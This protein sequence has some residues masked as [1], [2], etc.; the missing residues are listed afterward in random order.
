M[1][2]IIASLFTLFTITA[3]FAQGDFRFAV[4]PDRTGGHRPGIY[5]DAIRKLNLMQPEF[6]MSVGDLIEGYTEDSAEVIRQWEEYDSLIAPLNMPFYYVPGNHDYSNELMTRIWKERYG[7]SYYHFVHKDVLFLCMSSEGEGGQMHGINEK[8]V[9]Y[10]SQVLE[11]H[12]EVRWTLVF[13]HQPVWTYGDPGWTELEGILIEREYTVFAGH[14]H[15]Y[16]KY[17]RN[18]SRYLVLATAGGIS[19]LRGTGYGEFDHLTWVT[20][21]DSGPV[22]AN[23]MLDGI[24][25]EEIFTEEQLGLLG[26]D[27]LLVKPIFYEDDFRED[28]VP[29]EIFNNSPYLLSAT[30]GTGQSTLLEAVAEETEMEIPPGDRA[31]IHLTLRSTDSHEAIFESEAFPLHLS[32]RYSMDKGRE[33]TMQQQTG[34]SPVKKLHL[35]KAT[36]RM[37]IDGNLRE[38]K[39]LPYSVEAPADGIASFNFSLSS[40]ADYLYLGVEVRDDEFYEDPYVSIWEKDALL[41]NFDASPVQISANNRKNNIPYHEQPRIYLLPSFEKGTAPRVDQLERLPEG[42]LIATA[43]TDEGF[44]LEVALPVE[45]IESVGGKEWETIRFNIGYSDI[46]GE[47]SRT[48]IPWKPNWSDAASYIGSGTFFKAAT[49]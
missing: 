26:L 31:T 18:G 20:I 42:T 24:R 36:R 39:E 21:T 7:P 6:V 35:R 12:R 25:D 40:D 4:I 37:K 9:A 41:I 48:I 49:R 17:V 3:I 2:R 46:D 13:M 1:K 8:Q 15:L 43:R 14:T 10:F 45:F 47:G 28:T 16:T 33:V 30:L 11:N 38:W 22:V 44:N 23:L 34:L 5:E 32:Y 27:P 29:L 19:G